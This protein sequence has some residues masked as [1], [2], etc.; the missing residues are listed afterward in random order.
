MNTACVSI[1][2]RDYSPRANAEKAGVARSA[3]VA[4]LGSG[5]NAV[6][7][8]LT[9]GAGNAATTA[10]VHVSIEIDTCAIAICS[11]CGAISNINT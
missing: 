11:S 2:A 10:I 1:G 7:A 5:A 6:S 3:G 9:S 4:S 8:K